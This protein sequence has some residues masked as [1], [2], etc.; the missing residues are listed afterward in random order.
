MDPVSELVGILDETLRFAENPAHF[1]IDDIYS[2]WASQLELL[3]EIKE[4]LRAAK[5]GEADLSRL[6]MLYAPTAGLCEIVTSSGTSAYL[7]LSSRFDRFY[8]SVRSV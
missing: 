7:G 1:N 8:S 5:D 4:H 2:E 3:T 6:L